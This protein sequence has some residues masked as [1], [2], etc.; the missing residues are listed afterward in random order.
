MITR[1]RQC[2]VIINFITGTNTTSTSTSNSTGARSGV[3]RRGGVGGV[4][5]EAV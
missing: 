5:P 2:C 3:I 4:E 1:S